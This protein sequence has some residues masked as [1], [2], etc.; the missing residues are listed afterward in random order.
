MM[1][2]TRVAVMQRA[3]RGAEPPAARAQAVDGRRQPE[4][5]QPLGVDD[6]EEEREREHEGQ[7]RRV[8][9][10]LRRQIETRGGVDEP[11]RRHRRH[12]RHDDAGEVEVG[13][14]AA[15]QPADA[16]HQPA[17][18]PGRR[19]GCCGRPRP[20]GS[21]ATRC[22]STSRSR[23][24]RTCPRRGACR[25][26]TVNCSGRSSGKVTLTR[27]ATSAVATRRATTTS[28][29]YVTAR[30]S[31]ADQAAGGVGADTARIVA[32]GR[33]YCGS[34]TSTCAAE[35]DDASMSNPPCI[36]SSDDAVPSGPPSSERMR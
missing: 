14:R 19:R 7:Q 27:N 33:G 10:A 4:Q 13:L 32:D 3:G 35:P 12:P 30:A 20:T 34:K 15:E 1:P 16:A 36:R 24:A 2:F 8:P 9:G 28:I 21:R 31:A 6:A 11:G 23:S 22:R 26:S 18:R 17:G 29:S 25:P 5:E